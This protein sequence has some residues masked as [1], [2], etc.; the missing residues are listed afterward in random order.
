MEYSAARGIQDVKRSA[1]SR[2]IVAKFSG[3]MK[4]IFKNQVVAMGKALL[5]LMTAKTES[6]GEMLGIVENWENEIENFSQIPKNIRKLSFLDVDAEHYDG[7]KKVLP[8][9]AD[10]WSGKL[11]CINAVKHYINQTPNSRPF[12]LTSYRKGP[13]VRELEEWEVQNQL[14]ADVI[15]P[16]TSEWESLV[17][18]VS[19]KN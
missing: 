7:I 13:E 6:T 5:K 9:F 1:L 19:K 12:R 10:M 8:P 14:K 18:F 2:I 17:L 4:L 15:E 16:T 3:E 11:G